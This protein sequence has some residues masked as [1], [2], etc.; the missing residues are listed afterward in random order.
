M[1]AYYLLCNS[2][3]ICKQVQIQVSATQTV[4]RT[5]MSCGKGKIYKQKMSAEEVGEKQKETQL[6]VYS[7]VLLVTVITAEMLRHRPH[8]CWPFHRSTLKGFH[9]RT[10]IPICDSKHVW[11]RR[12]IQ[13]SPDSYTQM[14]FFTCFLLLSLAHQTSL[15]TFSIATSLE[16]SCF[17][18]SCVWP[19]WHSIRNET[20]MNGLTKSLK[21]F[22]VSFCLPPHRRAHLNKSGCS[23]THVK[24]ITTLLSC[25]SSCLHKFIFRW[26]AVYKHW[27]NG[28]VCRCF[29]PTNAPQVYIFHVLQ[30]YQA[31]SDLRYFSVTFCYYPSVISLHFSRA[32][33]F[34]HWQTIHLIL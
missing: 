9:Y 10:T 30:Y 18:L 11:K 8:P 1:Y 4:L 5:P 23:R 14:Q 21:D 32:D 20:W 22:H 13:E 12:N 15:L 2:S 25:S 27:A 34:Q 19:A 17:A 6:Y 7:H 24:K 3:D 16:K 26:V 28:R 29:F 33:I 31:I